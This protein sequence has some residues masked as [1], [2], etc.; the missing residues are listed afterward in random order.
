METEQIAHQVRRE[1]E[2]GS[3]IADI[4]GERSL[5]PGSRESGGAMHFHAIDKYRYPQLVPA[6]FSAEEGQL[7]GPVEVRGGYSVFRFLRRAEGAP[8]TLAEVRSQVE[9]F[10]RRR[11]ERE[12]FEVFIKNL[13]MKYENQIEV[14]D[15]RLHEALPD[16][17]LAAL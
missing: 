8:Q 10:V 17:F 3:D 1:I 4:A 12:Q 7:V 15:K 6:V 11:K 14:F 5:R 2:A 13:R 16:D 9:A